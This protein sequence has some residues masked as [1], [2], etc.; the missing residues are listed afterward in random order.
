M[1]CSHWL[2]HESYIINSMNTN[3]QVSSALL[4]FTIII[5]YSIILIFIRFLFYSIIYYRL[6]YYSII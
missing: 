6:L 4:L 5:D 1:L 2:I 3:N